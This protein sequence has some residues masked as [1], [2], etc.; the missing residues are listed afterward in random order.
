VL[1]GGGLSLAAA[2]QDGGLA[3]WIGD[4]VGALRSLHPLLL[5]LIVTTI[6]TFLTEFTSN[7]A[8]AAAFLP[9]ASSLAIGAGMNPLLL[10]VAVGLAAS[11]GFMMPV[12]TPPNAIVFG[13]GRLSI[14][15]MARAGLLVDLLFIVLVTG[16]SYLLVL[17]VLG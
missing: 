15:E 13:S 9:I 8:T 17:P 2:I 12:G 4:S 14:P 1:F 3:K 6:I 7:T 5:L 16:V 11:N 10:A